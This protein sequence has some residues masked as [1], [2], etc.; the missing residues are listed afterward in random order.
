MKVLQIISIIN[1]Y[2]TLQTRLVKD[3]MELENYRTL[4][5]D[6]QKE[7]LYLKKVKYD[8]EELGRFLNEE[9]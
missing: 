3:K 7:K 5:P 9:V 1:R 8:Y 6:E 4:E 2:N